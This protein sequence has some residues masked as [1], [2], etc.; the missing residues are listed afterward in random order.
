MKMVYL[1]IFFVV[2]F[3]IN[4]LFFSVYRYCKSF[5]K[6]SLYVLRF[7][8]P[9]N[10]VFK[11]KLLT[12]YRNIITFYILLYPII[13][14]N[15]LVFFLAFCK[16]IRF[17][18]HKMCHIQ[19]NMVLLLPF[20]F[21]SFYFIYFILLLSSCLLLSGTCS[22]MLNRSCVLTT[23]FKFWDLFYDPEYCQSLRIF[24]LKCAYTLHLWRESYK[25]H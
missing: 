14:L 21:A 19:I 22:I 9:A 12:I 24:L 18:W 5:V 16:F 6:L 13:L 23:D 4:I 8:M 7:S 2:V 20:Q 15:C 1:A 10:D 17:F 25:C 11:I 3:R